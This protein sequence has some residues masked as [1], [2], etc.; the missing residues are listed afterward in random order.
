AR[1]SGG[2]RRPL[3]S[4]RQRTAQGA[5]QALHLGPRPALGLP[6]LAQVPARR[7]G[8]LPT[9]AFCQSDSLTLLLNAGIMVMEVT[10][11]A[12]TTREPSQRVKATFRMDP[13]SL[14]ALEVERRL[15][16]EAGIARS[17]CDLSD[18]VNEAV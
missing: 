10:M 11:P 6:A 5:A 1:A 13:E 2:H 8:R 14:G 7:R 4:G 18:L 16:L 9:L 12:K 15:R 3:R 17:L